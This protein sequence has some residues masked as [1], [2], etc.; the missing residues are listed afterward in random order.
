MA[1]IKVSEMAFLETIPDDA[2]IYI[3]NPGDTTPYYTTKAAFLASIAIPNFQQ[4]TDVDGGFTTHIVGSSNA[5]YTGDFFGWLSGNAAASFMAMYADMGLVIKDY[6][7]KA[8]MIFKNKLN[9]NAV[10]LV[11]QNKPEADYLIADT[12]DIAALQAQITAGLEGLSWKNNA[13]IAIDTALTM[14]GSVPLTP[15]LTIQGITLVQD[16]RVVLMAQANPIY[17]GIYR[18]NAALT[19]G[20]YRLY[21][22]NDANLSTELTNALVPIGE[23]TYVAKTFRQTTVNPVINTSSILFEI[24]G[25]SVAIATDLVAGIMKL[26]AAAGTN[27]DGTI[28]Q[29][30]ITDLLALKEDTANKENTL[31]DNST[32][33]YPTNNLVKTYLDEDFNFNNLITNQ[34]GYF[35]PTQ[36]V[37]TFPNVMRNG[38]LTLSGNS[39]L[40]N[41]ISRVLF[42][43]T[44]TAGTLAFQRGFPLSIDA[45]D[46]TYYFNSTLKFD[47]SSNVSGS[48]FFAGW[49]RMYVVTN[50]TNVEPD[51]MINSIGVCKLS[52]SNNL[53]VMHNDASGLATTIDLGVNY[54]ANNILGYVYIIKLSKQLSSTDLLFEIQRN[55]LDSSGTTIST[56]YILS[57]NI[58]SLSISTTVWI[59]N[60]ATASI[61]SFEHFGSVINKN[62][63]Y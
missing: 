28:S 37:A 23:G 44:A 46:A 63:N 4:V 33:K 59:C 36:N 62:V 60:N 55:S 3:V 26:Y 6:G 48:R 27:T 8:P 39:A 30:I 43:T 50:P 32:T 42:S 17:N 10:T 14:S 47:I 22:T 20:N 5:L 15:T 53:H 58:P 34:L 51:T 29:K 9:D 38:A 52:T 7:P 11:A 24:F 56:S 31:L 54:P 45:F 35:L 1:E 16:D 13:R 41:P 25:S 57:T 61:A 2:K 40:T 49:S 12:E 19:S 21:R 18:V